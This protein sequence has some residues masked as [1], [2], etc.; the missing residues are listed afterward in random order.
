MCYLSFEES[1][2][3]YADD[4]GNLCPEDARLLLNTH[5]VTWEEWV[6]EKDF[7]EDGELNAESILAFLGY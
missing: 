2:L 1:V 7:K 3:G 6:R 5:S 4:D